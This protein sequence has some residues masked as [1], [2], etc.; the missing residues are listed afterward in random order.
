MNIHVVTSIRSLHQVGLAHHFIIPGRYWCCWFWQNMCHKIRYW[1]IDISAFLINT[2]AVYNPTSFAVLMNWSDYVPLPTIK[3]LPTNSGL[4]PINLV[5]TGFATFFLLLAS[6]CCFIF[7]WLYSSS[8][9]SRNILNVFQKWS[10]PCSSIVLLI[11]V[12]KNYFISKFLQS[13]HVMHKL[14]SKE[15]DV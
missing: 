15:S 10:T 12:E 13:P 11:Y 2:L 9:I 5:L 4:L 14:C 1:Y 3:T 6:C 8:F 7:L